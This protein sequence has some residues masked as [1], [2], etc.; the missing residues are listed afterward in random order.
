[1]GLPV[2]CMVKY[3]CTFPISSP[4]S[5]SPTQPAR[6]F[7]KASCALALL[8]LQLSSV[9][10]RAALG[11]GG[12]ADGCSLALGTNEWGKHSCAEVGA[13]LED[14]AWSGSWFPSLLCSPNFL[15]HILRLP[16]WCADAVACCRHVSEPYQSPPEIHRVKHCSTVREALVRPVIN[17][18]L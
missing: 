15:S 12:S 6:A 16:S 3:I 1:M 14:G 7:P 2:V 13:S 18:K 10:S 5:E 9:P 11:K 17:S 4:D 8:F